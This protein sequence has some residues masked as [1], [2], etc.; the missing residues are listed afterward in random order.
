VI[1]CLENGTPPIASVRDARDSFVVAMAAYESAKKDG[2]V[3]LTW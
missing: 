1:D 2:P 3:Y